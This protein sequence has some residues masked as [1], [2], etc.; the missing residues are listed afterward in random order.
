M[1][2]AII[3]H[4][5]KLSLY[6]YPNDSNYKL[7]RLLL[8]THTN[9]DDRN[10]VQIASVRLPNNNNTATK[11]KTNDENSMGNKKKKKKHEKK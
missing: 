10:Y 1:I 8:G 5:T 9:D 7:Q 11:G 6:S 4:A 3:I 2:K